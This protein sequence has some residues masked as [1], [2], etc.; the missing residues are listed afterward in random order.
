[1]GRMTEVKWGLIFVG[2]TLVWMV[3][4]RLVGLHGPRIEHHAS[5]SPLFAIPAIAVYVF[6]LR[7]KRER[8]L[9][10]TMTWTQGFVSGLI[11]TAVVAFLAPLTQWVTHTLITPDYFGNAIEA[12]VALGKTTHSDAEAHFN[13]PNYIRI[14]VVGAVGMGVATSAVVALFVRKKPAGSS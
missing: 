7:N 3:L 13:L 10:G 14:G 2:V 6:G 5:F 4:E 11:I 1:M 12:G 9:G 8:D